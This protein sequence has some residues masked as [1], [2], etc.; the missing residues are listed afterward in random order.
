MSLKVL[1]AGN[2][3]FMLLESVGLGIIYIVSI[4]RHRGQNSC[5]FNE[6]SRDSENFRG[7]QR[8]PHD[9][10]GVQGL[11]GREGCVYGLELQGGAA[12]CAGGAPCGAP[13]SFY[14][15]EVHWWC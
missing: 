12:A 15:R 11:G 14:T 10:E 7:L 6:P 3:G 13:P 2:V 4:T 8:G 1:S 9:P 5:V